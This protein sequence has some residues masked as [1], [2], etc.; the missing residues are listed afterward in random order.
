M[1]AKV[2]VDWVN[3]DPS[4]NEQDLSDKPPQVQKGARNFFSKAASR[5]A[6]I[7]AKDQIRTLL[8]V[9]DALK[10]IID[11]LTARH[12]IE[13]TVF[14]LTTDNGYLLGEH[15]LVNFKLFVYEAAQLP[16]AIAGPGF[17]AGVTSDAFVTNLDIAPTIE[18]IAGV[19]GNDAIVDGRAIQDLL[20][21]P[22]HGHD[23]FLPIFVPNMVP[24]GEGVKTW[25]YKYIRYKNGF[26]E[27]YDLAVDPYE[28]DNKNKDPDYANVKAKMIE[29]MRQ[30]IACKGPSCRVSAPADL[31]GT[32]GERTTQASG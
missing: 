15:H 17:P 32:R 13:N 4:Y 12:Q 27:L 21:D 22:N 19:K 16:L 5:T 30:A 3:T 8:S 2:P 23:R 10:G 18:R 7:Y 24:T 29:L 6:P 31:Q 25:R 14:I 28:L 11:D 26:E 9:D 20:S 1:Y